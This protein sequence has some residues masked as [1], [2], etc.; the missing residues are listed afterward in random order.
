MANGRPDA[1]PF[2]APASWACEPAGARALA[3]GSQPVPAPPTAAA[4]IALHRTRAYGSGFRAGS[5]VPQPQR[6]FPPVAA[7]TS[8]PVGLRTEPGARVLLQPAP[9]AWLLLVPHA[10]RP[11]H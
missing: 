8:E 9:L 11:F 1:R 5:R 2:P 3:R 7:H 10:A 4:T 6:P